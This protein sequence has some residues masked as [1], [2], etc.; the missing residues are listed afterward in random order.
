MGQTMSV[1]VLSDMPDVWVTV[2][3]FSFY[4]YIRLLLA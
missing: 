3:L 4:H 1:Y 2:S